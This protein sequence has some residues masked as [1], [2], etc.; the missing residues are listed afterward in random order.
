MGGRVEIVFKVDAPDS[1]VISDIV[2]VLVVVTSI[3]VDLN[4][5]GKIGT[6]RW[7]ERFVI[8]SSTVESVDEFGSRLG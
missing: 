7:S 2:V 4:G 1:S 8:G 5:S 3:Y 6:S